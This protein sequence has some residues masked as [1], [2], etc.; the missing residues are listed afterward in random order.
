MTPLYAIDP[1]ETRSAL[2]IVRGD[3]ISG[4]MWENGPLVGWLTQPANRRACA[5]LVIEQIQSYGMPVGREVF[6]TVFWS[7]RFAQAWESHGCQCAWSMLPRRDVKL[8]L[9]GS[10]RAKDPNVRQVLIDRFGGPLC[11]RKGG[12]LAGIKGDL[13]AALALAVTY[14]QLQQEAIA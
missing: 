10:S 6:E 7:G 4:E 2:V 1:G 12:R 3:V 5:H 14:Q 9:C 11:A 13:W 8:T